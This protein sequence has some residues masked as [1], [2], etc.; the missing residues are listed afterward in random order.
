MGWGPGASP[1]PVSG[2]AG[3]VAGWGVGGCEDQ[4]AQRE[5]RRLRVFARAPAGRVPP[6]THLRR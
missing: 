6:S 1:R 5:A 4:D 2:S 3:W